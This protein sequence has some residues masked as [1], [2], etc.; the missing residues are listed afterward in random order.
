MRLKWPSHGIHFLDD[1]ANCA[2]AVHSVVSRSQTSVL[3]G[4]TVPS[5]EG[6]R[7]TLLQLAS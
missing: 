2:E 3:S 4:Q 7:A 1:I 6:V 5:A